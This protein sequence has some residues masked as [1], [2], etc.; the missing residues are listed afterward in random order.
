MLR[1]L[2]AFF[3]CAIPRFGVAGSLE[4]HWAGTL[5]HGG[6][7]LDVSF[8][9][10]A[11]ASNSGTVSGRFSSMTQRAMDYPLDEVS[12]KGAPVHFVLAGATP[13]DGTLA[14]DALTGT[15]HDHD[16]T[17]TFALRRT[18]VPVLPYDVR[19]VAFG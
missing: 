10:A 11:A 16:G 12:V 7:T 3:A 4:G 13:P 1:C 19:E 9:F 6:V 18:S 17:G 8:D 2:V 14:T 5:D 15:F